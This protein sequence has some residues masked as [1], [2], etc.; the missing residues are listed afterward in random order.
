MFY[1]VTVCVDL[2]WVQFFRGKDQ[3]FSYYI[4]FKEKISFQCH[5]V[6]FVCFCFLCNTESCAVFRKLLWVGRSS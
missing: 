5:A 2:D 6:M 4:Q 3:L 1:H